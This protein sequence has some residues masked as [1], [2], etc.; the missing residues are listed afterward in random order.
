MAAQDLD[1]VG[2]VVIDGAGAPPRAGVTVIVRG[3][4]IEPIL[5]RAPPPVEGVRRLELQGRFLLPG[6]I[7]AHA[8]IESP[9][10]AL[11]ALQSGV[12]TARVLG[13]SYFRALGTRDLIRAGHTPGPELLVSGGIIRPRPGE[14]FFVTFPQFGAALN[15]ELRGVE[16]IAAVT[17]AMLERGVDLIKVAA[18][19]RAGVAAADPRRAEL[20]EDE[21]RAAVTEAA[22]A[23]RFVAAHAH[24]RDGAAAAVRA[25]VH[26]IEHGTYLDEPTLFEMRRRGTF[27][28]PTLA[29]MSPL[30]DPLTGSAD[31]VVL[32][33]RTRQM[34]GPVRAATRR[35]RELGITVAASTDGSYGDGDSTAG[36]RVAHDIAALRE[37]CGFTPLESILAATLNGARVLGIDAR[38]GA[39]RPGL[40]ADLLVV[41]RDPLRD[42]SALFEPLLVV[43]D[44]LV[45]FE[46][47]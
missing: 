28:V 39:I 1:L 3:G 42:G 22:R 30:S 32:Q 8:H 20:T 14:A 4:R 19:E 40:E 23:G 33:L 35:A 5:E 37:D 6:L 46:R 21:M 9:A 26:S 29:V 2:V 18:S 31:D 41:E 27:L 10:A 36:I 43:S 17:R 34:M 24:S 45:R 25:G 38:T 47:Q 11:R 44:G 7:D 16:R 13:D 12:T 15:G